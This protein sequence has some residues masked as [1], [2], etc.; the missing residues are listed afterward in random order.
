MAYWRTRDALNDLAGTMDAA[1]LK[2]ARNALEVAA[3]RSAAP[4]AAGTH[5]ATAADLPEAVRVLKSAGATITGV[6][7]GYPAFSMTALSKVTSG[8]PT[9]TRSP[10]RTLTS[11]P[12]FRRVETA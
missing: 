1:S 7:S 6:M 10:F 9:S 3:G 11:K 8:V 5:G 4:G 2:A 12:A